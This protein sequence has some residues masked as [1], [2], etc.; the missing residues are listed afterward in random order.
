M[1]A[2][3]ASAGFR[4]FRQS[5]ASFI[6]AETGNLKLAQRLLG[7]STLEMTANVY[8]HTAAEAERGAALALERAIHG[9]LFQTVPRIETWKKNEAVN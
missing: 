9:D 8:T 5:A 3:S 6:N 7:H 4:S 2:A 1:P